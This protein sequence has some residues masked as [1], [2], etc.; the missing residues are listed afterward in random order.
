MAPE[1]VVVSEMDNRNLRVIRSSVVEFMKRSASTYAV[2]Q[3]RLLDI[4]PQVHE[5]ARPFFPE[6]IA[7]ETLDIDPKS[8]CTYVGD[9]CEH[10]SLLPDGGFDYV[11][12][13]EVLEHTLRPW[14]A[15][16]EIWRILKPAGLL[17][18]SVPFNFR[19]HGPLPDCWHFT[20]HGLRALLSDRFLILS[21]DAVETRDRPLMPIHYTVTA[22]KT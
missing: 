18:L 13:T 16:A 15:V 14:D 12:C 21:L 17:F 7:V 2:T 5:G 10:N 1:Q 20:E 6:W 9:I 19:I 8:G 4:A 22:R 11:V 3:G